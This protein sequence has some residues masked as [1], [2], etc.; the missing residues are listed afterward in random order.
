MEEF[1]DDGFNEFANNRSN[2]IK[3]TK[4]D[5]LLERDKFVGNICLE[6]P[7]GCE[8]RSTRSGYTSDDN[9]NV[10]NDLLRSEG[11]G[12]EYPM[13][14]PSTT[15]WS[16]Q[17]HQTHISSLGSGTL[18]SLHSNKTTG[19]IA[20]T[21]ATTTWSSNSNSNKHLDW[22][23]QRMESF[24]SNKEYAGSECDST[25]SGYSPDKKCISPSDGGGLGEGE[26][27]DPAAYDEDE[28]WGHPPGERWPPLGAPNDD[29]CI[30]ICSFEELGR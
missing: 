16:T 26:E 25:L 11:S 12:S 9:T 4:E 3:E 22:R 24:E 18:A 21:A 17:T 27:D 13:D 29:D 6:V 15:T 23:A 28:D 1:T 8:S 2:C 7:D 10:L 5:Q 20:A 30:S 14:V 19:K